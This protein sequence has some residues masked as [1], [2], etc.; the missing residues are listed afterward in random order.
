M[1]FGIQLFAQIESRFSA[2]IDS[3]FVAVY[4]RS[5]IH[6]KHPTRRRRPLLLGHI[7]H[8][9]NS[10]R[11]LISSSPT[12]SVPLLARRDTLKLII[13]AGGPLH[14]IVV[15][16]VCKQLYTEA[17]SDFD[18]DIGWRKMATEPTK[19]NCVV[20]CKSCIVFLSA[21]LYF[22]KRGAY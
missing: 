11:R 17:C 14:Y 22:R 5:L 13:N 10:F 1:L 20:Q 19:Q 21:S 16:T 18:V 7:G 15:L 9:G 12:S 4:R 3:S 2:E 8:L 6:N